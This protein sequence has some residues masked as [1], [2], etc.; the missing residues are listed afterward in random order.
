MKNK[1]KITLLIFCLFAFGISP[2]KAS[3]LWNIQDG[4][5][6]YNQT[7]YIK[8]KDFFENYI[9]SNPNDKNGYYLLGRT[10]LKLKDELNAQK[11]FEKSYEL[12][13][14]EQNIEKLKFNKEKLS[15]NDYF[16]MSVM[17]FED[18]NLQE[19]DFYADMMLKLDPKNYK[20]WFVKAKVANSQN[21][22]DKA[23]EYLKSAIIYNNKLLKTNLAKELDIYSVPKATKEIYN[24]FALEAYYKGDIEKAIYNYNQYLEIDKTNIEIYTMLSEAYLIKND[25]QNALKT[26]EEAQNSVDNAPILYLLKAKA[27]KLLSDNKKQEEAL[28]KAYEA[29]PN[30]IETLLEIGNFYLGKENFKKAKPYFEALINTNDNFYEGYFGYIKCLIEEG[31]INSALNFIRKIS[32]LNNKSKEVD[33]LL[34]LICY[35][36][37]NYSE[38]LDYIKDALDKEENPNYYLIKAK[39]EYYSNENKSSLKSLDYISKFNFSVFDLS[40]IDKYYLKNYIKT[41][42]IQNTQYY[43]NRANIALDKNSL[44]YK[45]VLYKTYKL[46]GNDKKA[47]LLFKQI[48]MLGNNSTKDLL[49]LSEIVFYEKGLNEAIKL[50]DKNIKK[51]PLEYS[52]YYQ[53][54]KIYMLA[55]EIEKAKEISENIRKNFR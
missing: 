42:Q 31:N 29:N 9:K 27:Y 50:L 51:A 45:Y 1:F 15:L 23:K 5:K 20:A 43:I 3:L 38:A 26:L 4:A 35:K 46:Q 30:N 53:K 49:D 14:K 37:G 28:K 24:M 21:Q 41:Q 12:A 48:R 33:Y 52:L 19:A 25:I 44:L 32:T 7:D 10:Y 22:K 55:N 40:E 2:L 18:G 34:S 8:A 6:L 16:D 39:I 13:S 11:N 36:E 54:I 47:E 17:Y